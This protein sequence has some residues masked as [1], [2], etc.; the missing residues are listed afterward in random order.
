MM[1]AE[2]VVVSYN[3]LAALEV[4]LR[5]VRRLYPELPVCVGLQGPAP[6]GGFAAWLDEQERSGLLRLERLA[7]PSITRSI[8]H[9]VRTSEAETVLLLDDDARPCLGWLEA[10][11][12]AFAADPD[13]AYTCGREVR[14]HAAR[15]ALL[16]L[17]RITVELAYGLFLPAEYKLRGRIVGWFSRTGL[18]FGNFDLPGTCLINSP[19]GCNM[20]VRRAAFVEA[21][22]FDAAFAGN[23][24]G[25]EADFGL[26]LAAA[27]RLGRYVGD[28][29]VLHEEAA[30]GGSREA[31]GWAWL[32]DFLRNHRL[33]MRTLGPLGWV[34]SAPR[35]L[36]R[37][38]QVA[39]SAVAV[40]PGGAGRRAP[41]R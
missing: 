23:A 20:G 2:L 13:L 14:L 10:H 36:A 18:M 27:G 32:H 7:A 17:E 5:A 9:C 39:L 26:R 21:G 30:A 12:D 24:W 41:S 28:A 35:L 16:E 1:N 40:G 11:R 3:R 33:L 25:F 19:R 6:E 31:R 4:T 34:G 37:T 29:V 22:G 38:V 15:P 8:N